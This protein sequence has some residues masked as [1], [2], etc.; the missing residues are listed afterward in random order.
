MSRDEE[1]TRR[2]SFALSIILGQH[3]PEIEVRAC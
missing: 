3:V 2:W 1:A